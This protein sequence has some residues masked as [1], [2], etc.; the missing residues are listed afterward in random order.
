MLQPHF[1]GKYY[2]IQKYCEEKERNTRR[3]FRNC[4]TQVDFLVS[5]TKL[6]SSFRIAQFNLPGLRTPCR[7][8]ITARRGE[9]LLVYVNVG[10]PSRM[11]SIC[12]CPSSIQILP[13]KMNL[14]KQTVSCGN[15]STTFFITDRTN[16]G[17]R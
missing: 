17:F 3:I 14:K 7:K 2:V 8:D 15:I 13:V 4:I 11:I 5:E 10:I 9:G 12:D 6:D 1:E 16:E